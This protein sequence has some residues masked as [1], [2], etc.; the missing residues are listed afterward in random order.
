MNKW[1]FYGN[2]EVVELQECKYNSYWLEVVDRPEY[3]NVDSWNFISK[4]EIYYFLCAK[5]IKLFVA[6]NSAIKFH[7]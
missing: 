4:E 3:T 7:K 1:Y 5:M 6:K 2:R